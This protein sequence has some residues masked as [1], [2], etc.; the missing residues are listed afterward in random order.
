[1]TIP[2]RRERWI[3]SF[4]FAGDPRITPR[5]Q[6][7]LQGR[8]GPGS[9]VALRRDADGVWHGHRDILLADWPWRP[10]ER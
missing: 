5:Q 10:G 7:R 9:I 3:D 1:M 6:E 4:W 2:G 8:G